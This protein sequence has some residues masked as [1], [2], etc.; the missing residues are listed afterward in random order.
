MDSTVI[1]IAIVA[2]VIGA[3]IAYFMKGKTA[4][5]HNISDTELE[6]SKS[7]IANQKKKAEEL[8]A[9]LSDCKKQIEKLK[10]QKPDLSGNTNV[11]EIENLKKELQELGIKLE[12]TEFDLEDA[13]KKFKKKK[14]EAE[15]FEK[16]LNN[17]QQDLKTLQEEY[18]KKSIA[19]D[20]TKEQLNSKEEAL[21]IINDILGAK[22]VTDEDVKEKHHHISNVLDYVND[23]VLVEL[24]KFNEINDEEFKEYRDKIWQWANIQKKNWLSNKKTAAFVG[25]FSAGKTSI[26]N[27]ILSQDHPNAHL[28]PTSSKAT[29]AI[30]TYISYS[31]GHS[32]HFTTT[33]GTLKSIKPETFD[34]IKKDVLEQVRISS[35]IQYF[36]AN[37]PNEQLKGLSILDTPGFNSNDKEDA[38]R[39]AEVIRETDVLFWVFDSNSGEINQTS[40]NIIEEHLQG[41]PLYIIINKADTKSPKELKDLE[42][43]IKNTTRKAGIQVEKYIQFSQK[44]NIQELMSAIRSVPFNT[45]KT[46]YLQEIIDKLEE[47]IEEARYDKKQLEQEERYIRDQLDENSQEFNENLSALES[48]CNK[49]GRM[50]EKSSSWLGLGDDY[51]KLSVREYNDL[52]YGLSEIDTIKDNIIAIQEDINNLIAEEVENEKMLNEAKNQQWKLEDIKKELQKRIKKLD[53]IEN[54]QK[55]TTVYNSYSYNYITNSAGITV[56]IRTD[57]INRLVE[58]GYNREYLENLDNDVIKDIMRQLE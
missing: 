21:S 25:E 24:K 40:I 4:E 33:D 27:R 16:E 12:D 43:H 49:I 36:I 34:Q 19:L 15:N 29:T 58:Y 26:V 51:Y 50:G 17:R 14:E 47:E 39:T 32:I 8:N 1:I 54:T 48:H 28:L 31:P 56:D 22:S 45:N 23:T 3:T 10:A 20:N 57:L 38:R 9:Q 46:N 18:Q 37:Y 44:H 41:V 2:A 13:Q 6:K 7:Q 53:N 30:P 55:K 5:E 52:K 11:L 42:E 35:T